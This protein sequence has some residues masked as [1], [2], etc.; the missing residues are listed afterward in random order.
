MKDSEEIQ[1]LGLGSTSSGGT[2]GMAALEGIVAAIELFDTL[3]SSFKFT[4]K[5]PSHILHITAS[6]PD[7]AKH[8]QANSSP[9]LDE[10]TWETLPDELSKVCIIHFPGTV[11]VAA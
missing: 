7:N 3:A 8:P 2:T 10:T 9:A 6:F 5:M 4:R 1:Q 11:K